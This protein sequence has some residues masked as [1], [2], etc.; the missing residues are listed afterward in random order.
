MV[1]ELLEENGPFTW[2][3]YELYLKAALASGYR[4]IS[5]AEFFD[6]TTFPSSPFILLRHDID[7]DPLWA[8]FIGRLEAEHGVRSTY[9]FQRGSPFYQFESAETMAIVE[10]LLR[11]GHWLGLHF[12]A[13]RIVE[14][15]EVIERV[16]RIAD[17]LQGMFGSAI[18]A[19][20]F[21]MPTYRSV[22][23]LRL[24]N[25]RINT[26]GPLF[27]EKIEYISDSNQDWRGKDVLQVLRD[28]TIPRIQLLIHPIWWRE[29]YMSLSEK[30]EEL[31][32]KLGLSV[33]EILTS[34]QRALIHH[35]NQNNE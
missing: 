15:N 31:S 30:I 26:Y 5:F 27:F 12:D 32:A 6:Q 21:H 24:R 29:R 25:N 28:G 11:K 17:E 23:H 35:E 14:D 1:D 4:F 33:D 10:E 19:V 9:F 34:E 22:K 16:D 3:T 13:T 8:L 18:T 7:Y 2:K 20:S